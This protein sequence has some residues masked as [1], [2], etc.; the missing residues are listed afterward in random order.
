MKRM[1]FNATHSEELRVAIV[2]GQTLVDLDIEFA[3]N[4]NKRG[5]IYK[6]I[7]T[8]VEPSLEAVFVDYGTKR[9]GFLSLKDISRSYFSSR[10]SPSVSAGQQVRIQDVIS[11]G[12]SMIV[13]VEKNERGTKGAALTTF[14]SLAGRY[15]VLLPNNPRGGGISRQIE[16]GDR[17]ELKEIM[18]QLEVPEEHS[19]I[20]RTA[21]IGQTLENF[22]ADLGILLNL[23][24]IIESTADSK[25]AAFP[26]YQES[27]LVARALRDYLREDIDQILIDDEDLYEETRKFVNEVLPSAKVQVQHYTDTV[28]LFSRYQVEH[29]IKDAFERNVKLPNGGVIVIEQTEALV[30]IDVNSARSTK[31]ADIEETALQ[32]NLEAVDQI[33]KQ[34]RVRDV[35][36]LIVI[37]LIDM[38]NKRNRRTV[39]KRFNE[40]VES[41][42]AR[43]RI[44]RI[45]SFGLLEMSR[46][47][48]RSSIEESS[49][50]VC[51]RCKGHGFIRS[52][53]SSALSILRIIEEEALK[54]STE[55]I[56]AHLPVE[57]ATF[58]VNEKRHE[59]NMI[60]SRMGTRIVI[61][62]TSSML[63]PDH[64]L[65]KFTSAE[66][67]DKEAS[68]SYTLQL[69]N[70][71]PEVYNFLRAGSNEKPAAVQ[72][73]DVLGISDKSKT[74]GPL[75]KRVVKSLFG[76]GRNDA[77]P[78]GPSKVDE[79]PSKGK[80]PAKR[81]A[82]GSSTTRRPRRKPQGGERTA[83]Q[84]RRN[85]TSKPKRSR[86]RPSGNSIHYEQSKSGQG[87][88]TE[89]AKSAGGHSNN[90]GNRKPRSQR[91]R[92]R[93]VQHS[94]DDAT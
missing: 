36:G 65:V 69:P 44:G 89:R 29:Q 6:G 40:A 16:G 4:E 22:Q 84:G 68:I 79:P 30:T 8:K 37:D 76:P 32:T 41:D 17:Y 58:L 56:H 94:H 23:W 10:S 88:S 60:E 38:V 1:L 39:E 54:E 50:D 59:L 26:I 90:R 7:V 61:V 14:I 72:Q 47:R 52:A 5:N 42:R 33:A 86:T 34:L 13:Q 55:L 25:K 92:S 63:T 93:E 46:Q 9:Q 28:P 85:T 20:A 24:K 51:P 11:V 66:L 2:E 12:D 19:V 57:A 81:T 27:S 74:S 35:G 82:K 87:N 43:T 62:P 83:T 18:S 48:L 80:S 73:S 78:A 53:T 15:L 67:E 21:G 64:Q 91:S 49:H 75:L 31:G 45:S 77:A 70:R 3:N 71:A